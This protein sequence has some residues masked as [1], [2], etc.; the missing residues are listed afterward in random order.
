MGG[1]DGGFH[2]RDGPAKPVWDLY[3]EEFEGYPRAGDRVNRSSSA[4]GDDD[5][6]HEAAME[7]RQGWS[8][9]STSTVHERWTRLHRP[10]KFGIDLEVDPFMEYDPDDPPPETAAFLKTLPEVWGKGEGGAEAQLRIT[11]FLRKAGLVAWVLHSNRVSNMTAKGRFRSLKSLVVVG[12]Q[13]GAAGFGVGKAQSVADATDRA[14]TQAIKNMVWFEFHRGKALWEPLKGE[15]NGTQALLLPPKR[16]GGLHVGR[17]MYAVADCFGL[18][19]RR[20]RR[21]GRHAALSLSS[22]L[23]ERRR[24]RA[25]GGASLL[26]RCLPP[27]LTPLSIS[28]S[29]SQSASHSLSPS[30]GRARQSHRG[31]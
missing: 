12:N 27:R 24:R 25:S 30:L 5:A 13:K 29:L 4:A 22:A 1:R 9:A 21:T 23:S 31:A 7:R 17:T 16:G 11:E 28:P 15:H 2:S 10:D 20:A 6:D 8:G 19:V 14:I 26:R 18:E 3:A